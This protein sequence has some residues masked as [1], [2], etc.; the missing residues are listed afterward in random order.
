MASGS[1]LCQMRDEMRDVKCGHGRGPTA[2]LMG[3]STQ[4]VQANQRTKNAGHCEER[5][6]LVDGDLRGGKMDVSGMRLVTRQCAGVEA[7]ELLGVGW[8]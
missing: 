5:K 2:I 7:A 6:M 4:S 1:Q 3:S 8:V